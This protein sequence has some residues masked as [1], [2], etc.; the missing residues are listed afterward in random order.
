VKER[1]VCRVGLWQVTLRRVVLG[2]STAVSS[3]TTNARTLTSLASGRVHALFRKV[4]TYCEPRSRLIV[5]ESLG[6][7]VP[8]AVM[9]PSKIT[10]WLVKPGDSVELGEDLAR[11]ELI[12]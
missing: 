1:W 8:H 7:L 10:E 3:G 11:L 5:V 2:S 6:Q 4:G 12:R 9:Y